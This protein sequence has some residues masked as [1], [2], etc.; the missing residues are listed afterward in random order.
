MNKNTLHP[1]YVVYNPNAIVDYYDTGYFIIPSGL[2]LAPYPLASD[3]VKFVGNY[4][5]CDFIFRAL[6]NYNPN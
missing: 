5:E 6:S 1:V 3:E 4:M 2:R